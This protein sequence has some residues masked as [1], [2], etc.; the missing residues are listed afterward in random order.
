MSKRVHGRRGY[1]ISEATAARIDARR[2]PVH[3]VTVD[4]NGAM[5]VKPNIVFSSTITEDAAL[6]LAGDV[7]SAYG[8]SAAAQA[9]QLVAAIAEAL[10]FASTR[11]VSRSLKKGRPVELAQLALAHDIEKILGGGTQLGNWG[12]KPSGSISPLGAALQTAWQ[13][14]GFGLLADPSK[15]IRNARRRY[16]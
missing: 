10:L 3:S 16:P 2:S 6:R 13:G 7:L 12:P 11:A 1:V 9:P 4:Q 5:R 15:V 14:L 8:L